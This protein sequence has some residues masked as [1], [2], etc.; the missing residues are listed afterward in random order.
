ME[1]KDFV[2]SEESTEVRSRKMLVLFLFVLLT[3]ILYTFRLFYLQIVLGNDYREQSATISN[4]G[5]VI[6]AQRGEIFDRNASLPIV[7]NTDSFAVDLNPGEIPKGH[8]DTVAMKLSEYLEINK[9]VI[10]RKV[11][12]EY[13]SREYTSIEIKSNVPLSVISNIAENLTDLPGVSWRN[14]PIRT[15][16][17]SGSMS[18]ILGYVGNISKNELDILYNEGYTRN[19]VIGKAGIEKQYDKLLQG[20]PGSEI[21]KV[22]ARG[23]VV[24]NDVEVIPPQTGKNIVLTID[25]TVQHLVEAALGD[26]VGASVVIKP[27]TGEVIAMVSYPYFDSNIF[28]SDDANNEYVR[29]LNSP[30]NPLVNRVVNST[31]PPASTFKTIMQTAVLNENLI[32]AEKK[33]LCPGKFEYGDRIFHCHQ[34]AG[35]GYLNLKNAYAQSCDVYFYDVGLKLGVDKI[36]AYSREFGLGQSTEIDLPTQ[37]VGVVPTPEWNERRFQRKWLGGDTVNMSIGQG[38]TLVTPLHL[39]NMVAM[40]CNGGTIYKPH[41]LKEVRNPVNNETIEEVKPEVLKSSDIPDSVWKQVQSNMRYM[42]TNGSAQLPMNCKVVQ[43]A[44]KTGTAEVA[45]AKPDHWHSWMVAYAPYDAPVEDQIVI[46]TVVEAVNDWEWWAP[47]ATNIIMQGIFA[48][49]TYEEAVA[50]L[51]PV[52]RNKLYQQMHGRRE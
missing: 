35:H 48:E 28:S 20:T 7:I 31:Y 4:K 33:I 12:E 29:L 47:Y 40:V 22:D 41:L 32:P 14:K 52:Y 36:A 2:N 49:Q 43:I 37:K 21:R 10:D 25:T 11:P 5:T 1:G 16:L 44:G 3:F 8:Y 6:E 17:E 13:R 19:S 45:N 30:N 34:R 50:A 23:R 46:A 42:I 26:R 9:K 18:H 51:G 38:N 24:S 39:A 15:Y 27:A